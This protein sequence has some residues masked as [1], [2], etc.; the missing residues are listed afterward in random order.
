MANPESPD[1]TNS[2][3]SSERYNN[4]PLF[5]QNSDNSAMQL[6]SNKLSGTNFQRWSRAVK[7]AL[8]TK[9][10]LGFIDGSCPAPAASSPNYN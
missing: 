8:V 10:K 6:V 1:S 2:R 3:I 9:V 7:I 4:D 5:L